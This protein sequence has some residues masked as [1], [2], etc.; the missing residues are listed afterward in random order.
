[1]AQGLSSITAIAIIEKDTNSDVMLTWSYPIVDE[2]FEPVLISRSN[3]KGEFV[4]FTFSKF[5]NQWI[6]IVSSPVEHEEEED[7]DDEEKENEEKVLSTTGKEYPG[8]LGRVEAFSICLLCKDYNPEMYATLAKLFVGVYTKTGTPISIL[9]G[10]LR[11]LTVGKLGDFEK[12]DFPNRDALLATSIKDIIKIFGIEIILVWTALMMKK[13]VA[14]YCDKSSTLLRAIRAFPLFIW[15][16][17]DWDLLYPYVNLNEDEIDELNK[18]RVYCAGFTDPEIKSKANLYDLFID[19]NE[20]NISVAEH[21]KTD[22]RMGSF[23][24]DLGDFLVECSEDEEMSDLDIIKELA[25]RTKQLLDKL[26]SLQVEDEDGNEMITAES[27]QNLP[28][29]MQQFLFS[30]AVAEGLTR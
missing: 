5:H 27:L 16:R 18:V 25:I 3:L 30:V 7:E 1:M 10:F 4:P 29:N 12:N 15:H 23:H 21:A 6:Y 14:V 28:A 11:V 26:K 22:F 8:P 20:R 2:S 24:K 13:R 17:R 19:L 9:Q